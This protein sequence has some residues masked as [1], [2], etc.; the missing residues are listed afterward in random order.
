MKKYLI[1]VAGTLLF[2]LSTGQSSVF[3][4]SNNVLHKKHELPGK[5][6]MQRGEKTS[7]VDVAVMNYPD[8]TNV[9]RY[10]KFELGI[11]L[12]ADILERIHCFLTAEDTCT[13]GLNP[14]IEW[15]VD[16]EA[17]FEHSSTGNRKTIDGYY[18]REYVANPDTD[19]WDDIGTD[20]PF[21]IRFA[22][23]LNGGW[24]GIITIRIKGQP[25]YSSGLFSFHVTESGN[26]GYVYVHPNKK[27]LMR[28]DSI[29][30]PVGVNFPGP[31]EH[32]IPWGGAGDSSYIGKRLFNAQNT[33]KATNA[34]EWEFF[35]SKVETYFRQ[36]GR[37][38]RNI[39]SPW[40][41]LIEF[42][43][44]GN[45]YDRLHYAWEQD[46]F[47]DL[48]ERYDAL[49]MFNMMMHTVIENH[50]GYGLFVWDWSNLKGERDP[51]DTSKLIPV[52]DANDPFPVYCYNNN[53]KGS[54]KKQPHETFVDETDL[55]FHEQRTRYYIARYGYSTNIY[56]FELLSEP[57]NINNNT[58][59]GEQPYFEDNTAKQQELFTAIETYHERISR[60]IKEKME[61]TEHLIGVD[62]TMHVWTP[63]T[64]TTVMDQSF[65]INTVDIIGLN[66]YA[67]VYNKYIITKN[68]N[69]SSNNTFYP[70]ENSRARAVSELH[71]ASGKPIILSE[72]GDGDDVH[73]CSN[74]IGSY[75]DLMSAGF[76]GV[77]G[78]NLWEGKDFSQHF[79]WPAVITA[80]HHMN[81]T[82][83]LTTLGSGT[84][85]WT[86]GR[87]HSSLP[88]GGASAAEHQYYVSSDQKQA[89]GYVRNRTYN[90]M[91]RGNGLEKCN[92]SWPA[93]VDKPVTI[94]WTAF[95]PKQ[96]LRVEGL[97]KKTNY[98]ISWYS[99]KEGVYLEEECVNSSS[100]G[101]IKLK[102]PPLSVSVE[103]SAADQPVLWYIIHETDCRKEDANSNQSQH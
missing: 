30:F 82:D 27:N 12:P 41:S 20:Y 58:I 34:K 85:N 78:Y 51:S 6:T 88:N 91:T 66:Y 49:M 25:E 19:D 55:K 26:P 68:H 2:F 100:K 93:P 39:Q 3:K 17:T 62:Y 96:Q 64:G 4:N 53:P 54:N 36:G 90:I 75:I 44:K 33:H 5:N 8:L 37:Y 32:S 71:A 18:H 35:L 74:Y 87:Q 69:K 50:A 99:Y 103:E 73:S 46:R 80:Q 59:T 9:L 79:L 89:A 28:G 29:I 21:R 95:K 77:C 61:H 63:Y 84:G 97:K 60:F 56:E 67:N 83:V 14:F 13:D 11:K 40:S 102:H 48:C 57:F 23:P 47:L 92:V 76:T 72:F 42:E 22:P 24:T 70:G 86:Q 1:T 15:E 65:R 94:V 81:R 16:V 31:E 7:I 38:I 45:Y 98:R 52:Y 10:R 43:K 101:Y